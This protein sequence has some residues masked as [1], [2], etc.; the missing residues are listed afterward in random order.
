M[1]VNGFASSGVI[2]RTKES[3]AKMPSSGSDVPVGQK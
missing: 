1:L 3:D 2:P